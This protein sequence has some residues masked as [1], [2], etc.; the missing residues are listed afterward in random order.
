MPYSV[1]QSVVC[2]FNV[3]DSAVT[4]KISDMTQ[5]GKA[6]ISDVGD[7]ISTTSIVGWSCPD[8]GKKNLG[9]SKYCSNCGREKPTQRVC[10]NCGAKIGNN[11]KFCRKCGCKLDVKENETT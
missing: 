7:K 2:K 10:A 1:V 8:C 6:V 3:Q 9:D 4:D 11:D 5:K